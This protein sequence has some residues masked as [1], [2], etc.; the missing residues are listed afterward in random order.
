MEPSVLA[1]GGEVAPPS[2]STLLALRPESW[3]TLVLL[4]AAAL[5]GYGWYLL[6]ARGHRWPVGRGIAFLGPGLGGIAALLF[7]YRRE[8]TGRP[9]HESTQNDTHPRD[10][11]A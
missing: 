3:L 10:P 9:A 7:V 2:A 1:H 5:Y 4:A 6:R 11:E 8:C